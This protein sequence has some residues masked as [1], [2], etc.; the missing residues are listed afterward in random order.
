MTTLL[1]C[2]A[3]L[4]VLLFGIHLLRLWGDLRLSRELKKL[5]EKRTLLRIRRRLYERK[6]LKTLAEKSR[7]TGIPIDDCLDQSEAEIRKLDKE[8]KRLFEENR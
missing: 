4:N 2:S 6:K 8:A 1:I 7:I 3:V 5:E